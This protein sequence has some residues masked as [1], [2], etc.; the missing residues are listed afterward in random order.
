M[1]FS[2]HSVLQQ[3]KQLGTGI[4]VRWLIINCHVNPT[5]LPI[6]VSHRPWQ[7][8]ALQKC[9]LVR[10][11]IVTWTGTAEHCQPHLLSPIRVPMTVYSPTVCPLALPSTIS[12]AMERWGWQLPQGQWHVTAASPQVSIELTGIWHPT[13]WQELG[14]DTYVGYWLTLMVEAIASSDT[15]VVLLNGMFSHMLS[16]VYTC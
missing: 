10:K 11:V 7:W 5:W 9:P 3:R 13:T 15:Y 12:V 6:S 1:F 4:S 2:F 8:H 16:N 14:P